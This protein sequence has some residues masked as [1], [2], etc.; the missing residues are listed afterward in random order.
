ML[1]LNPQRRCG[2]TQLFGREATKGHCRGVPQPHRI[3]S[4]QPSFMAGT[5]KLILHIKNI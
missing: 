2:Y 3:N 1:N 4:A 5:F